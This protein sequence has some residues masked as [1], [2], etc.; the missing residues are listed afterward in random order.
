M[1]NKRASSGLPLFSASHTQH[2][3]MISGAEFPWIFMENGKIF[4]SRRNTGLLLMVDLYMFAQVQLTRKQL[5]TCSTAELRSRPLSGARDPHVII[6]LFA[7][8]SCLAWL[9]DVH[10]LQL[11]P[12]TLN[13][14]RWHASMSR[15]DR[16]NYFIDQ[17]NFQQEKLSTT[18]G[19][20]QALH[21][22]SPDNTMAIH[23]IR[24]CMHVHHFAPTS[25][26]RR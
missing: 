3:C 22:G 9:L 17:P 11:D 24:S 5:I 20:L 26:P 18:L 16:E 4:G 19:T 7:P 15:I 25:K 6:V 21:W 2:I 10:C 8:S 23:C 1:F 13:N 12:I 14:F